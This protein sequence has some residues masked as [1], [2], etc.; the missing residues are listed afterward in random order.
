LPTPIGVNANLSDWSELYRLPGVRATQAIGMERNS[1]PE[2]KVYIGWRDEGLYMGFEVFDQNIESMPA[3]G[4]WWTRDSIE[5]WVSTRPVPTDQQVY[6]AWCHQFYFV[7]NANPIDGILGTVGQWHRP[8]DALQSN[9]V[10]H[11]TIIHQT[12]VL[13]D[14][15]TVEMFIPSAALNG[16]NPSEHPEMAFNMHIRNFHKAAD[17]FWSAPKEAA[18]QMRPNTWGKLVLVKESI[19]AGQ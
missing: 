19:A 11:P 12:R 10:P 8:G 3:T 2:P 16:W 4:R 17:Y 5:F 18:T 1:T 15:Y 13:P 7:P 14:R 6:N 9:L